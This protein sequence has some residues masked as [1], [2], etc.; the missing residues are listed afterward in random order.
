M[1]IHLAELELARAYGENL[2]FES[3]NAE[4]VHSILA[5]G[6]QMHKWFKNHPLF[7]AAINIGVIAGIF[8]LDWLILLK[9]PAF[10]LSFEHSATLAR[11]LTGIVVGAAHSWLLYSLAILSLHEGAAHHMIFPGTGVVS[12]LGAF[13]ATNLS[14]ISQADP[15]YYSP[16][17]MP[18]HAKFGTATIL[19]S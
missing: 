7:H 15:S 9:L 4:Q 11:I 10:L 12:R 2:D 5:R 16:C 19:S 3:L 13:L 17:H 1:Q 8:V 6:R 14:R 18:H